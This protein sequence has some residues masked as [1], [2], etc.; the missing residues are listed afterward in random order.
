MILYEQKWQKFLR[1]IWPLRHIPFIDFVFAAGSL[2]TGNVREESDFDVII[3]VRQGRIFIV[4]MLCFVVFN[5]MGAWARHPDK[6]KD[7]LCFNHFVTP[8]AYR[9][10]PP[11]NEYWKKLYM[12]LVPIYG[13]PMV[14]QRFYRANEDWIGKTRLYQKDE[15]HLYKKSGRIKKICEWILSEGSGS[16]IRTRAGFGN[17]LENQLKRIQIKRIEQNLKSQSGYKPRIVY[18]DNELEFHPDTRRTED[19]LQ[20]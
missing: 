13:S 19:F 18:S 11:Y 8:N 12:S 2:A 1:Q 9:L 16:N 17:W 20:K 4:R 14:I 3:G 7:R 15:R 6:S 10:S 5:I